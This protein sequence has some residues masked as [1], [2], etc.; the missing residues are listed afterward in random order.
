MMAFA[1][2]NREQVPMPTDEQLALWT[3]IRL[4]P[5]DDTPRLVYADWL[6]EHGEEARAE[7]I[8][9]QCALAKLPTDRR[10][11]RKERPTLE[12]REKELF[13]SLQQELVAV[14]LVVMERASNLNWGPEVRWAGQ[15][16]HRGFMR[17]G[18]LDLARAREL[19]AADTLEPVDMLHVYSNSYEY[20]LANLLAFA[21]WPGSNSVLH[22]HITGATNETLGAITRF[23]HFRSLSHL[24]LIGSERIGS[25]SDSGMRELARWPLATTL[26]VVN[27]SRNPITHT[28]AFVLADSPYLDNLVCL[29]LQDTQINAEGR[30]RLRERFGDRVHFSP[31]VI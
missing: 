24:E 11:N 27:L 13:A 26:H 2:R 14:L 30:E 3:A 20:R 9:V 15:T 21:E 25:I 8:R 19:S 16:F 28:G 10:K 31:E 1:K 12:A 4:N 7:F 23:G 18:H 5:A 17:I 29:D 6:Q 22:L